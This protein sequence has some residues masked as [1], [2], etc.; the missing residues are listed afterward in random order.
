M[1]LPTGLLT[2]QRGFE[3]RLVIGVLSD[4]HIYDRGQRTLPDTIPDLFRRFGVGLIVHCGDINVPS[5]LVELGQV[6]PLMAVVGNNDNDDLYAILPET[7]AFTVGRFRFAAI[8]GHQGKS[9]RTTARE[10]FAGKVDCVLY[11]HS[12]IPL[13]DE[14][15]G[16]VLFNPGSATDRRWNPHFGVGIVTVDA[17]RA[18][19]ELILFERPEHLATIN[20][21]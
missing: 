16:T 6:A 12:H 1:A 8:H 20:P 15:R 17:D 5:V 3:S 13:M 11:G 4:T 21:G 10:R 18:R 7:V 9:A 19:P 14:A 2:E